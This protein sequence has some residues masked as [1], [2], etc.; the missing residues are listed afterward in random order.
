M[1]SSSP[2]SSI[3]VE[4]YTEKLDGSTS[5]SSSTEDPEFDPESDLEDF[6]NVPVIKQEDNAELL[7]MYTCILCNNGEELVGID[8]LDLLQYDLEKL[9]TTNALR[10]RFFL[11]QYTQA[12]ND[13][14]KANDNKTGKTKRPEYKELKHGLRVPKTRPNE[15]AYYEDTPKIK[16]P[17]YSNFEKFWSTVEPYCAPVGKDNLAFLDTF[18]QE[19]ENAQP[20]DSIIPEVGEYFTKSWSDELMDDEENFCTLIIKK[21][22]DTKEQDTV[23]IIEKLGGK[24]TERLLAATI[25]DKALKAAEAEAETTSCT[26]TGK[27]HAKSDEIKTTKDADPTS[28][29]GYDGCPKVAASLGKRLEKVLFEEGILT[30]NDVEKG[31]EDDDIIKEIKKCKEELLTINAHNVVELKKLRS[32]VVKNIEFNELQNE[33]NT[34][35]KQ[36]LE[37]YNSYVVTHAQD[38]DKDI[39]KVFPE[40]MRPELASKANALF[41]QR[42][43]LDNKINDMADTLYYC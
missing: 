13:D 39:E 15:Y 8:D 43:M 2:A 1:T 38:E 19:Q 42:Y 28:H 30:K 26:E 4:H 7:P 35:D 33:L 5:P 20:N 31:P 40:P 14:K 27:A 10:T 36:I 22:Q 29:D 32:A 24:T 34:V 25:Y 17:R 41:Q 21:I 6:D 16:V 18:I 9:L 37:L 23:S 11:G 3:S 12:D